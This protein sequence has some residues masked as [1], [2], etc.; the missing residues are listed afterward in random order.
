MKCCQK[1]KNKQQ[2]SFKS[3]SLSINY[4]SSLLVKNHIRVLAIDE[5]IVRG[6]NN[7]CVYDVRNCD[8]VTMDGGRRITAS[9][10]PCRGR[11]I[12]AKKR[13]RRRGRLDGAANTVKKLQLREICSKRRR[14][15]SM[16]NFPERFRNIRLQVL[17][18]PFFLL[19]HLFIFLSLHFFKMFRH[20]YCLISFAR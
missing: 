13:S 7:E 14:S 16:P 8:P 2:T 6:R 19:A 5:R 11:R 4:T 9:P 3:N 17:F 18:F 12:V 15:F 20:Y 10:R 1:P